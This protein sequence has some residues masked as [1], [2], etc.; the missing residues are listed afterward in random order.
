MVAY[1]YYGWYLIAPDTWNVPPDPAS[2]DT[3]DV[4]HAQGDQWVRLGN[5]VTLT[6]G[7]E[8]Q[9]SVEPSYAA[10][11]IAINMGMYSGTFIL[12][13]IATEA[14]AVYLSQFNINRICLTSSGDHSACYLIRILDGN[15]TGAPTLFKGW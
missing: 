15:G 7:Q 11:F 10:H 8:S 12:D 14:Q 2:Y 6:R 5:K 4:A 3:S 13:D 1:L 9:I